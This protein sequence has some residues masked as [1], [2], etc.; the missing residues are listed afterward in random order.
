[1]KEKDTH[2][3]KIEKTKENINISNKIDKDEEP[4]KINNDRDNLELYK[5]YINFTI[6]EEEPKEL[7]KICFNDNKKILIKIKIKLTI[8]MDLKIK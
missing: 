4:N 3:K 6:E 1:M 2:T 5:I 8:M 7:S